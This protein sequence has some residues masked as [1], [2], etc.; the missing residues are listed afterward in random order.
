[1]LWNGIYL[2]QTLHQTP[3]KQLRRFGNGLLRTPSPWYDV[4]SPTC[5]E[6]YEFEFVWA[7]L[8]VSLK[9]FM[10]NRRLRCTLLLFHYWDFLL[11]IVCADNHVTSLASI[12]VAVLLCCCVAVLLCCCVAVLLCCCVAVLLCCCVAVLSVAVSLC[13]CVAVSLC[14]CVAVSLCCCVAVLLCCSA[15][16]LCDVQKTIS[17]ATSSFQMRFLVTH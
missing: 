8:L 10:T 4:P 2:T 1:M 5:L 12:C 9:L 7:L 14:C 13:C 15:A 11:F 6:S 3:E 16:M 17:G